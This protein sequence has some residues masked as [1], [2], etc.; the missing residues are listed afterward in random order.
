MGNHSHQHRSNNLRNKLQQSIAMNQLHCCMQPPALPFLSC[1]STVFAI[2]H[3][4]ASSDQKVCQ[5][6]LYLDST[7]NLILSLTLPGDAFTTA[8]STDVPKVLIDSRAGSQFEFY[9]SHKRPSFCVTAVS[10]SPVTLCWQSNAVDV[11]KIVLL[12]LGMAR[13]H[14][15]L[16]T[17]AARTYWKL[18]T[19]RCY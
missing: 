12:L 5:L 13:N 4:M 17:A 6:P 11:P 8:H 10:L 2:C 7:W 14:Y 9:V 18:A 3:N 16:A 19:A 15:K 1:S